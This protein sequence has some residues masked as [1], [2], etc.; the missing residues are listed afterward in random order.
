VNLFIAS[1]L[2][3]KE[4]AITIRQETEFPFRDI[5][6]LKFNCPTET[7]M[8][9]YIRNPA[10]LAEPLKISINGKIQ[11]ISPASG[12]FSIGR[13]W[14]TGDVVEIKLPMNLRYESMPDDKKRIAFFY[15]P[16]LLAGALDRDEATSLLK[17]NMPPCLI[18]EDKPLS[19]WLKPE[20]SPLEYTTT[21]ARP[22]EIKL[23]PLFMLKTGP[24]AVFWQLETEKE[25]NQRT[26]LTH[27]REENLRKLEHDTFD[28]VIIGDE[29]SE[30]KHSLSGNGVK[31]KGNSGILNDEPWRAAEAP[32]ISFKMELP[33]DQPA[34]LVCK[35]MGRIQ[36]ERWDF[37]VKIDTTT[38][39]HVIRGMDDSYPVI[40]YYYCF[41][42]PSDLIRGR[43]EI[44]V[45]F[46]VLNP[47]QMP[48]LMELLVLR[49]Q[50][51]AKYPAMM[52]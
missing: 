51:Y 47:N 1:E 35:F 23:K 49:T 8:N 46:E 36:N 15:G 43:K 4:K 24:Y 14:K 37:K 45:D 52:F 2:N 44:K 7:F 42:L 33:G 12:Y 50:G 3:W 28:K 6:S 18:P 29:K 26:V 32:G 21:I 38:L 39:L 27:K 10:W 22:E 30:Q 41:P 34:S 5:T 17:A 20:G 25:W 19:Q 16:V 11:E 40:P 31:G 13:K 48:R 9:L